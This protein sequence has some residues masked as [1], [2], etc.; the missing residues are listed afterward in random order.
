MVRR[1]KENSGVVLLVV[2][3]LLALFVL[4]GVTY[5]LV[6]SQYR[7]AATM[8]AR[9][10][11]LHIDPQMHLDRAMYQLVRDTYN[12][13]SVL[14][15]HGL[16][17]DM[18][19]AEIEGGIVSQFRYLPG[20]TQQS[21]VLEVQCILYRQADM[22]GDGIFESPLDRPFPRDYF[23]GRVFSFLEG[24]PKNTSSRVID[25]IP[26]NL[27]PGSMNV[28]ANGNPMP[29]NPTQVHGI[30]RLLLPESEWS[31]SPAPTAGG[32]FIVNGR[33]F[34]GIGFGY[35]GTRYLSDEALYPNRVLRPAGFLNYVS[36][37]A[38]E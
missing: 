38:D 20:T 18:Y 31:I 1:K 10:K 24:N 33:P 6:A 7:R 19:G 30:F 27:V 9:T 36:G 22:D 11:F 21:Q 2:V 13:G 14:Q 17:R 28:D 26:L 25:Y 34:N 16:L 23:N 29:C 35:Q 32:R 3:S 12:T 4:I 5:V 8:D 15:G 37:G